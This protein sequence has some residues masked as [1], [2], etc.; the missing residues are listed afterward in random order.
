MCGKPIAR[1]V[2]ID[3]A[4]R[5]QLDNRRSNLRPATPVNN[6]ANRGQLRRGTS[7]YKGVYRLDGKRTWTAAIRRS[8][9][10][11]WLGTFVD[12]REAAYMYDQFALEID[13]E[14]ACPNVVND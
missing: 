6:S 8:N 5:D 2:L 10:T 12:E 1:N 4:N 3:H 9:K 13:G 7:P 11:I 14:F